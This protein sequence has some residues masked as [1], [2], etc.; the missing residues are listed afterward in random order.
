MGDWWQRSIVTPGKLPLLVCLGAFVLT[1]LV[2]RLSTRLIRSGRG[3]LRNAIVGEGLHVHHVVP[4]IALL[5]V[6]AVMGLMPLDPAFGIV[7]AVLVGGGAS[8]V[9]DE[10]ANIL[11]LK[12]VYWRTEGRA[13]VQAVALTG[14]CLVAALIGLNPL[15]VDEVD[16]TELTARVALMA[17]IVA[18]GIAVVVCAAK[19]KYRMALLAVFIPFVAFVGAVRLARPGSPWAR[20]YGPARSARAQERAARFD[21]RVTPLDRL[22]D[23]LAGAPSVHERG[24]S[25]PSRANKV[26]ANLSVPD[27]ATS[28]SFYA[29]FLGLSQEE[30]SLGWVARHTSPDGAV[31]IQ[32]VTRDASAPEDSVMTVMVTDVDEAYA[33]A[34]ERGYEIVHPLTVEEWGVRRFF[35]RAPDGNVFNI[36]ASH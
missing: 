30:F 32:L 16:A 2:T 8:L 26:I 31:S 6:G 12:D 13:S 20:R 1:F 3:P 23:L 7:A 17:F 9:L 28:R 29:D 18:T 36:V 5:I 27:L 19:G 15:G 25:E 35:V 4:G 34:R 14:V 10:F 11:H 33:L 24:E 22:G 21:A